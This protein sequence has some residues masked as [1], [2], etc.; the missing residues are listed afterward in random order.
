MTDGSL[1]A[2]RA[3]YLAGDLS[4]AAQSY[5]A[6]R[7]AGANESQ[8][9]LGLGLIAL[10]Q[11]NHNEAIT[12]L[13]RAAAANPDNV[14]ALTAL[15]AAFTMAGSPAKAATI[16]LET[17]RRA[18]G[19]LEPRLHLARA[20]ASLE[21]VKDGL[22]VLSDSV[23]S[24]G[25]EAEFWRLKGQLER[26]AGQPEEAYQSFLQLT[27]LDPED[28]NSL[29]D[30]G[31]T[32]RALGRYEDA[33]LHYREAIRHNPDLAVAHGNL[34]NV[35]DLQD[36]LENAEKALRTALTLEPGNPDFAYNLAAVLSK[37]ERPDEA[38]RFLRDVTASTPERWDAWTNLGVAHLDCGNLGDAEMALRKALEINPDNPEAHY[39]L[40]WLLL[41]TDQHAEGWR[42]LEW[43]WQLEDFS[44]HQRAF[45]YPHWAG[46]P[47]GNRTL[48]LHAEQG[49]G[50]TIQFC[51]FAASIP[52][53][54]G[55]VVLECQPALVPLLKG[56]KG[57]DEIIATGDALP[58]ADVHTPLLSLPH[59]LRYDGKRGQESKGYL[60]AAAQHS[61][62]LTMPKTGKRRI[63][64]VW[65][66]SPD[67]KIE[68]RRHVDFNMF[69]PLFD[70]TNAD[71]VSL[72]TG[73]RSPEIA[74]SPE[75]RVIFTCDGKVKDFAD[76][77]AV[78]NQ[79]DLV[80][81]VDTAVMHLTGALGKPGWILLPYMPD[82]R[83][84]LGRNTTPWYDSL[85]LF[86]Q[87]DRGNWNAVF[88]DLSAALR[89]W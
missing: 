83:W 80:I 19:N 51:R 36:Q 31:V 25:K 20:F 72:Q 33:E 61:D 54:S 37:L 47:L 46:D 12:H 26:R 44:S 5:E 87:P 16:L 50:D 42:E 34:G 67:N 6:A 17:V 41:L 45:D 21:R 29:N 58:L 3:L 15:G 9:R 88:A 39:N 62:A 55:R 84:G 53:K 85:R 86:R 78:I 63:G 69:L 23:E 1:E 77:A 65:A 82:Y 40:A 24:F 60:R 64:L 22:S 2:A 18:P 32:S 79:L 71:F 35:L 66:G 11:E 89:S 70:A 59:R 10:D 52:K 13:K 68:R 57:V 7:A 49:F 56:M 43:R 48:L 73:P 76:T 4:A 27:G 75:Y 28:A 30:L 8:C 74:H 38:V 81:G 14:D